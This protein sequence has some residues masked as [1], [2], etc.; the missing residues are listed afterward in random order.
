MIQSV[1]D[2]EKALQDH[3]ADLIYFGRPLL[4]RPMM[5]LEAAKTHC[6][7]LIPFQYERG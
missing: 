2:A 5:L 7:E 4:L 6:P 1:D 3:K